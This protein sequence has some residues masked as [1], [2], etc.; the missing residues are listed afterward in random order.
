MGLRHWD[1]TNLTVSS[2]NVTIDNTGLTLGY[3]STYDA[4]SAV[5]FSRETSFGA[6][7]GNVFGLWA[8]SNT[9][10]Y[11]D[12]TLE[13]YADRS[14]L[15]ADAK[16]SVYLSATGWNSAG[17]VATTNANLRVR[18]E[19]SVSEVSITST[20][21]AINAAI[22]TLL[23]VTAFGTHTLSAGGTGAN[24]LD[25]INTT[26]GTT[27]TAQLR[28]TAG[29]TSGLLFAT[30]QGYTAGTYD[31]QAATVLQGIGAG[32]ISLA[33]DSG[34]E[35][36]LY[37]NGVQRARIDTN[38]DFVPGSDNARSCG[39]VGARWTAVYAVNGTIQT[40][41]LDL[42]TSVRPSPLGRDFLLGLKP[43]AWQW[44]DS[45]DTR[46]HHGFVAQDIAA[47]SATFGGLEYGPDGKPVG[48]NYAAFI[49]P[50]VAG[51]QGHDA[52][53]QDQDARLARLEARLVTL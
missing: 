19:V 29:T 5:K 36:R 6:G 32:G 49:A 27:N 52:R 48:L 42:K 14:G 12:L 9:S 41:D 43:T 33:A 51:F 13:N 40:S 37:T 20:T 2:S 8:R 47:A 11:Q 3:A 22:S 15:G 21:F 10:A 1:G 28:V 31:Q 7:S 45:T 23:S 53:L 34:A 16:A 26:S 39:V 35:I 44:K 25:V 4:T 24:R 50:L 46:E 18:S 17:N 38:G 30:S